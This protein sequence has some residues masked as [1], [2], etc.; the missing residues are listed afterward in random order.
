MF[1]TYG[2]NDSVFGI[3]IYDINC[4]PDDASVKLLTLLYEVMTNVA[5]RFQVLAKVASV[6]CSGFRVSRSQVAG[7]LKSLAWPDVLKSRGMRLR[8][9][10]P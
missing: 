7:S 6:N 1:P 9:A 3:F 5:S 10:L 4:L 8:L 2:R